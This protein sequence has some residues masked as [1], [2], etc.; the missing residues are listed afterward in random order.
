MNAKS[1]WNITMGRIYKNIIDNE[2]HGKYL[3]RTVQLI[4]HVTDEIKE[5]IFKIAKGV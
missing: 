5:T 3:G 2:R 1:S 4:P